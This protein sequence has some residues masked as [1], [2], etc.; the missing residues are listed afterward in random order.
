MYNLGE[1]KRHPDRMSDFLP[2]ASLVAPGVVLNK[3][4]SLQRSFS[5]RG[6]DLDSATQAEL[7][8]ASAR[9]NNAVKRLSGGWG[10]YCEAQRIKSQSYAESVF[11]DPVTLMIDEERRSFFSSG[12]HYESLYYLTIV[13]LPPQDQQK[14]IES[15]FIERGQDI[16]ERRMST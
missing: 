2:W 4:G 5:F 11:P 3:D 6:P 12:N 14:K 10:I 13:Y 7:V 1:F 9:L 16:A 8:S 15:F